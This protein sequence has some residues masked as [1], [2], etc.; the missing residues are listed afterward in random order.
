MLVIF[1]LLYI[2][3]FGIDFKHYKGRRRKENGHREGQGWRLLN[4]LW[5]QYIIVLKYGTNITLM[6]FFLTRQK[7][8][9][10][11]TLD[12]IYEHYSIHPCNISECHEN[13]YLFY[14]RLAQG[15][16]MEARPLDSFLR[17]IWLPVVVLCL[18]LK[19]F[20][21]K[22]R[23]SGVWRMDQEEVYEEMRSLLR[24]PTVCLVPC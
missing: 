3:E 10:Y 24:M 21:S 16:C 17:H 2:F 14:F 1:I 13:K 5:N 18:W 22:V 7:E 20:F 11:L 4:K 15:R 9:C 12:S 23:L 8:F 19:V 6:H